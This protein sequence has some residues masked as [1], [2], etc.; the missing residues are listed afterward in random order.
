M[1]NASAPAP[2]CDDCKALIGA[3]RSTKPHANL[4]YKDGRKV[5]SMMGAAD[6]AYYGC[7]GCG[8]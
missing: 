8:H 3:S 4:E 6:E 1:S 2:M 7:K 5:L